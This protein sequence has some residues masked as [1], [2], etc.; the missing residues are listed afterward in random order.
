MLIRVSTERKWLPAKCTNRERG[1]ETEREREA[2][3]MI[4]TYN[5]LGVAH[6]VYDR[7]CRHNSKENFETEKP[8]LMI[9]SNNGHPFGCYACTFPLPFL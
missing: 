7:A 9:V 3:C 8:T 4:T 1:R 2:T 5:H 6:H